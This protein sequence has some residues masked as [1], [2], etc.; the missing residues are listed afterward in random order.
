MLVTVV[1]AV[2]NSVAAQRRIDATMIQAHKFA[3][4]VAL[5]VAKVGVGQ[6]HLEALT[7]TPAQANV[8]ADVGRNQ[9]FGREQSFTAQLFQ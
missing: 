8:E 6:R 2:V 7:Q 3:Y 5:R 1:A 4:V 9:V